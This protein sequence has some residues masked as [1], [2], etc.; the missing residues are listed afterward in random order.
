MNM[1]NS[2]Y[3]KVVFL[4]VVIGFLIPTPSSKGIPA[5]AR[6]YQISCQVCHSPVM[7]R[8]KGFG[9]EFAGNGFRMTEYESPRH[10]IQTGD[11]KLSLFRELPV[12]IRMDGYASYNFDNRESPDIAAPFVL[13]ILS[14]GE[15]SEK[16][17]YYF[18]FLFSERGEI[19]GLEDALLVYTDFMGTGINFTFGQFAVSD[20]LFK[21]ELRY[22]L[23]P[24]KIY[25]SKPGTSSADLKY[26]KGILFDKG[27][28][29]GTTIVGQIINGNGIGKADEGYIFDKDK[30]KN[31]ML[32][33]NQ[34]IGQFMTIG[35]FGYT[36][37][38]VIH[39][40]I[41]SD[42]SDIRMFGPDITF[43][44]DEKL[45]LSIQFVKRTDS[46]VIDDIVPED[47]LNDVET[48]GAFAE[49]V[50]APKGDMSKW[51]LTGLVNWVESDYNP[52]DYLSAT[53]HAGY[54]LRR[55][56]RI[57]G[58]F[59]QQF[60]GPDYGKANVGIITAF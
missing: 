4:L 38:E 22:T 35:F 17:S 6:K 58:E 18:Y 46:R 16:L 52:L 39:N 25:A 57:V 1:K 3:L 2:E 41:N 32:R 30:Y 20:P 55:N 36:G 45:M 59:T 44:F 51:Y 34:E 48:L 42:L 31:L 53:F 37:R 8:L 9:D 19:A 15:I 23:E 21:G 27:F 56:M 40:T 24:Y 11:D 5:F 7:P 12:A 14:G 13:K 10:F 49:L 47:I 29:T 28:K 60:R 26:D 50:Y 33:I 43:D 54:L